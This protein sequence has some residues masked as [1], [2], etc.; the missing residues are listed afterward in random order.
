MPS[1]CDD[2]GQHKSKIKMSIR[3][4]Q[5]SDEVDPFWSGRNIKEVSKVAEEV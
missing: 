3:F 4:G 1:M 2:P 5:N